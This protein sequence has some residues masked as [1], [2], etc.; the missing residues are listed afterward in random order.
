[1]NKQFNVYVIVFADRVLAYS[2]CISLL[3]L[4]LA[5]VAAILELSFHRKK[6]IFWLRLT[7]AGMGLYILRNY[8]FCFA[9]CTIIIKCR[10][11]ALCELLKHAISLEFDL[12]QALEGICDLIIQMLHLQRK[13]VVLS[14]GGGLM[15]YLLSG[16]VATGGE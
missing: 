4:N 11:M 9:P 8:S 7:V 16:S 1:V 3:S 12:K 13:E 14:A 10:L 6:F 5:L 15:V 2:L